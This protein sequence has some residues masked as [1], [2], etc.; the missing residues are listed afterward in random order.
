MVDGS[1]SFESQVAA[2]CVSADVSFSRASQLVVSSMALEALR[3]A[4][5]VWW[6]AASPA[7]QHNGLACTCRSFSIAWRKMVRTL[8]KMFVDCLRVQL[9][10]AATSLQGSQIPRVRRLG[11]MVAAARSLIDDLDD[12][13][14]WTISRD[15]DWNE[16]PEIVD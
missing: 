3:I 7:Q 8:S 5:L 6:C 1:L 12:I 13:S 10:S 9:R 2:S 14:G 16:V 4:G 11:G 15:W